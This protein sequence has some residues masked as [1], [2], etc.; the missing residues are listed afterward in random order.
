MASE[1]RQ[2]NRWP[3]VLK[4]DAISH[5]GSVIHIKVP[6][7]LTCFGGHFPEFPILPGVVQID[8]VVALAADYLSVEGS[9]Q[10][11]ERL[12]FMRPIRPGQQ[13][14]LE[15]IFTGDRGWLD[16]TYLYQGH[17][18]SKGRCVYEPVAD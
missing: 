10:T 16:F 6:H 18:C 2:D 9:V 1:V 3:V 13:L 8:W 11:I 14:S 7:D 15:L 17:V 5:T 12:K 4:V